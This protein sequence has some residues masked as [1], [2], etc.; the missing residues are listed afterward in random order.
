MADLTPPILVVDDDPFIVDVVARFLKSKG[1]RVT[2]TT[3]PEK[4]V[5]LAEAEIPQ[6]IISDLAMPGMDGI[7]LVQDFKANPKTE[8]IPLVLLTGS[9][10]IDDIE[11]GFA[12]GAAL[13]LLKPI[14]WVTAWPKLQPLL[15]KNE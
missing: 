8:N 13:Y 3:D 2:S 5:T 1:F 4:A 10:K 7:T 9:D 11:K 15:K 14:D 6:L 12:A